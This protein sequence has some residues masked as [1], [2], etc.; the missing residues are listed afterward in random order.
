MNLN[1]STEEVAP[2]GIHSFDQTYGGLPKR[3]FNLLHTSTKDASIAAVGHFLKTGIKQEQKVVLI[4]F[5]HPAHLFARFKEFNFDFDSALVAEQLFYLY[6]KPIFS[7]S[8]NFSTDYH[9]LVDEVKRLAC[10]EIGRIAFFNA[11]VLFNVETHLLAETSAEKIMASFSDQDC[12]VLG[13]YQT[14]DAHVNA[15]LN[16]ICH[17]ALRS[18]I[19]IRPTT[20]DNEKKYELLVHKNPLHET[21]APIDLRLTTAS[22]F[23]SPAMELI[24]HG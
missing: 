8:L 23:N 13:C 4:S 18:Y 17:T 14:T 10:S 3:V 9:Q 5:D 20:Q 2:W 12:V 15:H 21:N 7:F 22:G 11:E 16:Q 19:E 6:Y 1:I 24:K